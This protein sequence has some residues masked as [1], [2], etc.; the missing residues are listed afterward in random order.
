MGGIMPKRSTARVL[1]VDDNYNMI[2]ILMSILASIGIFEV[3]YCFNGVQALEL[4]RSWVPDLLI[5]DYN[6]TPIDGIQLTQIIRHA[7]DSA[8]PYLPIIMLSGHSERSKVEEARDAGVNEYIIK[9]VTTAAVINRLRNVITKP[10]PFVRCDTY[11]G[12]DR[13]RRHDPEFKGPWRRDSDKTD[14]GANPGG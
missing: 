11:V 3:E 9:P 13:R 4:I 14:H 2:L 8:N 10:R 1:L 6:M 7:P 5:V 12:P